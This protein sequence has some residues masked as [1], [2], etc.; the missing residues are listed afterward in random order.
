MTYFKTTITWLAA[1][2][3]AVFTVT[4]CGDAGDDNNSAPATQTDTDVES[5]T[6]VPSDT[7]G[8]P[9]GGN[10][11]NDTGT[12]DPGSV[13]L[14]NP[15]DFDYSSEHVFTMD[16]LLGGSD[17]V[18]AADDPSLICTEGCEDKEKQE[19]SIT[20]YPVDNAFGW[21]AVDYN[22]ATPRP[23]DG[24]YEEG[25]VGPIQDEDGNHQGI[26]V[27]TVPTIK[28]KTG[29]NKGQWCA[30]LGD[31]IAK[32]K[33]DH[34]VAME[35]VLT[36]DETIPYKYFDPV[37]GEPTISDYE[38]CQPLDDTLDGDPAN[39]TP[40][41]YDLENMVSS[42]DY[43]VINGETPGEYKVIWGNW[44]KR[45]TDMRFVSRIDLPDEWKEEGRQFEVTTA[46]L[47]IVHTITNNPNDKVDPEGLSNEGAAG[48]LPS[49]EVNEHGQWVS[50]RDCYEGDGDFIPA[51]TVLKNPDYTDPD[52]LTGDLHEG[53]TNAWYTTMDRDPF[54][55]S[56]EGGPRWRLKA[57]KFGQDIPG[58][59]IPKERCTPPPLKSDQIKYNRGDL[60]VTLVNLL[61]EFPDDVDNPFASSTGWTEPNSLQTLAEG[62][63]NMTSEGVT[64]TE[65]LDLSIHIKGDKKPVR[66]YKAVLYLDYVEVTQ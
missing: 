21:D 32:C 10:G 55:P 43:S 51:G 3:L 12:I 66:L 35:H 33:S 25:W 62:N 28:Y 9:D 63:P 38:N 46:K 30:G 59:E 14:P 53:F 8:N 40:Y 24:N 18:R 44:D 50:T 48:Q 61:D 29:P 45:P 58:L 42:S 31:H 57:P 64:L 49:Y 36:C 37:T 4:A 54:A 2:I 7:S 56:E 1:L 6:G 16:D 47:A 17:G 22:G 23:R 19:G 65:D 27:A 52:G 41:Q 60:T 39:L 15:A 5:D 13:D 11:N 34:Y 26:A 20:L